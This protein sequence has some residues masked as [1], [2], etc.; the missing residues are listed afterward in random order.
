VRVKDNGHS[1]CSEFFFFF[2]ERV[3]EPKF[4]EGG[5]GAQNLSTGRRNEFFS[6]RSDRGSS[7]FAYIS[8]FKLATLVRNKQKL[9]FELRAQLTSAT[10][11]FLYQ[12]L[13]HCLVPSLVFCLI[14]VRNSTQ[15]VRVVWY[16]LFLEHV[17]LT[18][19]EPHHCW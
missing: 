7:F 1:S 14:R 8:F 17:T 13:Y 18:L 6:L 9:D 15:T 5:R 11:I 12:K 19:M 16:S 4:F 3:D 2:G 10:E